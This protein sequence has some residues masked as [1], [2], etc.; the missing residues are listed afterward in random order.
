MV[1]AA[2]AL[3]VGFGSGH[4]VMFLIALELTIV[5]LAVLLLLS[6]M[7]IYR[8]RAAYYQLLYS[9]IGLLSMM[10]T[11]ALMTVGS[12]LIVGGTALCLLLAMLPYLIKLPI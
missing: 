4:M 7:T 3:Q 5:L 6:C 10:G 1:G 8:V 12:Y 11:L 2:L 9:L